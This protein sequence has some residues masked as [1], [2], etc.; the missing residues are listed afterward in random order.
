[1]SGVRQS[2]A[3]YGAGTAGVRLMGRWRSSSRVDRSGWWTCIAL[4]SVLL[5]VCGPARAAQTRL[6]SVL[7]RRCLP[8]D[9]SHGVSL[10]L[11]SPGEGMLRVEIEERGIS[12]VSFLRD[13]ATGEVSGV[14]ADGTAGA[15]GNASAS[16]TDRLGTVVLTRNLRRSE[17]TEVEVRVEDSRDISGAVC[18]SADLVPLSSSLRVRAELDFAAAGRAVHANDWVTAFSRYLRAARGFD[19]L[20]L[21]RSA[22]MARHAMAELAYLRFELKRDAYALASAALAGYDGS[23]DPVVL[24][25]LAELEAKALFDMPGNDPSA[26]APAVRRWLDIARRYES[27]DRYGA[28]ELP[29]I[30]ILA[31]FLDYLLNEL[32]PSRASFALAAKSCR[33]LRD[34]DCYAMATQNLAQLAEEGK[35]YS[36]ALSAYADALR[37]L[38]VELDPKLVATIW[39][40]L[41]R[42]QGVVGLFSASERSHTAA[43]QT[44]ARLGD[45]LGVRRSL[46]R[47]GN[48]LVHVGNLADAESDLMRAAS[49]ECPGLLASATAGGGGPT[50]DSSLASLEGGQRDARDM[51]RSPGGQPCAQPLDPGPLTRETRVVVLNSLL[52]LGNEA[53]LRGDSTEVWRCLDAAGLYTPDSRDQVR[54]SNARGSAFLESDNAKDARAAFA[55]G[56]RVSDEAGLLTTS[57]DRRSAQLGLVKSMLLAGHAAESLTGAYQALAV[58]TARGDIEST[59]TSLRLIAA[60]YRGSGQAAEAIHVL[61]VATDLIEAVPIDELNG[62]QRATFLASQHTAFAELADIFASEK[63]ADDSTAWLAFAASESGRARSLRYALNQETRNA[64]SPVGA[65]P[66]AKYQRLLDEVVAVTDRS[67]SKQPREALIDEIDRLA[68]RDVGKPAPFDRA[69]LERTLGQLDA[70]LVEYASGPEEMLAFVIGSKQVQVVHLGDVRE[71]ARATAE[72][73]DLLRDTETPA[74]EVHAAAKALAKLVWWPITPY[75]RGGRV[76]VVPD[77]AL[78]TVP[79][80]ALPWSADDS[81]QLVL[82]HAE[83]SVIPSALFLNRVR[84]AASA[85]SEMPRIALIGDPVFRVADWH[86]ECVDTATYPAQMKT[87]NRAL[88]AWTESLPR[89]PGTRSEITAIARL[90][91]ESRPA[92]RIE[93]LVGCAAVPSALRRA[94]ATDLDLLH[95]ATHARIDA[96]RPRLSAL[97]FT[98][99]SPTDTP[100]STFGLLDI[101]GLKLNS[102]LVVLSA[103]DTSRG[104]L[105]PGEGVLGPAQAFLQAGSAAVLASYWRVDDQITSIFMQRFYKYLL[106]DRLSASAALRKTQLES[107]AAGKTYEWAAFSLY[108][109]P[110]SSI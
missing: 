96:Q 88:S 46:A 48:L 66:L 36:F 102:K 20:G 39:N 91:R 3:E 50:A 72:L 9:D 79:L 94:A 84:P 63:G 59:I 73:R 21:R 97:A 85:H 45:C 41:G 58:S 38:P 87:V 83:T 12:T 108:G 105:L 30:D 25:A 37:L 65:P 56:L 92:S 109:W 40:N 34:W 42:L 23:V 14:G 64:S 7:E 35:D 55:R 61:Q 1:M 19:S 57:E 27:A 75:L 100:A 93:T 49:L 54:L 16:P 43:M 99:E 5:C 62:E 77:D 8:I 67:N 53:T 44:Y 82:Q 106:V 24:G 26:I 18:I 101:L 103:C 104:R 32:E 15:A 107:A 4:C 60:G 51:D 78:H 31:G 110:D 90:A 28:R 2:I 11:V 47:A 52:A 68:L 80:A 86:R 70:T 6:Q 89:L 69:Q 98:P 74:G 29:R 13:A 81:Q 76:V 95:I 10:S 33:E 22:A 71:I 17:H